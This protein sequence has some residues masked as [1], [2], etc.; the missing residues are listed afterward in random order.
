[1]PSESA[2]QEIKV[3][4]NNLVL[5]NVPKRINWTS[6][7]SQVLA[8][9]NI[10]RGIFY[11]LI[12]LLFRPGRAVNNHLFK[13]RNKLLNP[14][15]F[16]VLSSTIATFL[17]FY[18]VPVDLFE[19]SVAEG[20]TENNPDL[21]KGSRELSVV[22]TKFNTLA[23]QFINLSYFFLVPSGALFMW[24]FCRKRYNVPELAVVSCYIW[25]MVNCFTIIL[26]PLTKF[27]DQNIT[28]FSLI[29]II[30][31]IYP[32]FFYTNFFGQG[33]RGFFKGLILMFINMVLVVIFFI[34][35]AFLNFRDIESV[36]SPNSCSF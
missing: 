11:T 31:F 25:S 7:S 14:I 33:F 1:M 24:I 26:V 9:L 5:Q 16:L 27:E 8:V 29:S 28:V 34:T 12:E 2:D 32:I 4:K 35:L 15:R 18:Y 19:S 10:E 20:L 3:P 6:I 22:F 13:N 30:T 17:M 21:K 23:K 36:F